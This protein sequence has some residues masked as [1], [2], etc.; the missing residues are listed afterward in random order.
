M[1]L[2][3]CSELAPAGAGKDAGRAWGRWRMAFTSNQS[4]RG[5][6]PQIKFSPLGF[7]WKGLC[8]GVSRAAGP[9]DRAS[10]LE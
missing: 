7:L 8:D 10:G 9:R 5:G 6:K 4:S 1:G 2:Q 3:R